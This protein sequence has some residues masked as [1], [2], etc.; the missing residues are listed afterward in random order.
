MALYVTRP[1]RDEVRIGRG[2]PSERGGGGRDQQ[3]AE[4]CFY[5]G[6]WSIKRMLNREFK[7][8][9]FFFSFNKMCEIEKRFRYMRQAISRFIASKTVYTILKGLLYEYV[10]K[11]VPM[12]KRSVNLLVGN[13][14]SM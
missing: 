13:Y 2:L 14:M 3:R 12:R 10:M 9:F 7:F 6:D 4:D 1:R 8:E 11:I 5:E